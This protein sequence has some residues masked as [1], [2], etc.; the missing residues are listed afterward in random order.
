ME[1]KS[2][3]AVD[4]MGGDNAPAEIVQGAVDAVN[5]REDIKV[6]LTGD[7][8]A[9]KAELA[10]YKYNPEQIELIHCTEVIEMAEHPRHAIT[11]KKDSSMVVAL[12]LVKDGVAHGM[13]SA[14]NSGALAVGGIGIVRRIDGVK[15][16]PFTPII[17]TAKGVSLIADSGANV[18]VRPD[19]I[20]QFAQMGSI[21]MEHVMGVKNP[22][23]GIINCGAEAEKGN[24]LVKECF[25]LLEACKSIN[26]IGSVE[27]RDIPFGAADV[28]VCDGFVGNVALKMYEGMGS[29]LLKMIKSTIKSNPVSMAGGALLAPTLKK[30]LSKFDVAEHGGAPLMGLNGT[31]L[32]THGSAKHKEVTNTIYQAAAFNEQNII[33]LIKENISVL[34]Q[35]E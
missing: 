18:D 25:P 8:T 14:G 34:G 21:Y 24:A 30:A 23:V 9:V 4:A 13:V 12:K 5:A 10:K 26:F 31:V 32:K 19:H 29:M 1:F 28:I 15:R 20:V 2:V 35:E 22:T 11:H 7:E 33:G 16:T 27:A 3:V 6:I 17:P